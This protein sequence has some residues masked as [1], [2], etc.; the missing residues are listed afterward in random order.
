MLTPGAA[1]VDRACHSRENDLPSRLVSLL[2]L[3]LHHPPADASEKD[4]PL[5]RH[6]DL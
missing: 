2:R 6:S 1:S 3:L 5:R 4:G